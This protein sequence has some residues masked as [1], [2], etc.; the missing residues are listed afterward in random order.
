MKELTKHDPGTFCWVDLEAKDPEAAKRFYSELFGWDCND[1]PMDGGSPYTMFMT[2][3]K[4][5]GAVSG[6]CPNQ[7]AMGANPSWNSYLAVQSVNHAVEKAK[8]LGATVVAP[9]MDVFDA[10]RM[11]IIKD[12]SGAKVSLWEA[13]S[14]IGSGIT[15]VPG[16]LCW[17][18]LRT[19]QAKQAR[20]FYR[21]FMGWELKN[22]ENPGVDYSL[23]S[24]GDHHFGGIEKVS[25]VSS[26]WLPYFLVESCDKSTER[27]V[28]LGGK[29]V[30]GPKD[31]SNG[32]R[33]SILTD[34]QGA[35]FSIYEHGARA[36]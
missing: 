28:K 32:G 24:T 8:G 2:H 7:K 27:A 25:D 23:I 30:Q 12:P 20:A 17:M 18:E 26:H 3:G 21:D 1:I 35:V 16:T 14:H 34:P 33:H 13:K 15:H 4:E 19:P 36:Q 9:P 10:G 22:W 6:Q 31:I 29:V 5:V 11:A